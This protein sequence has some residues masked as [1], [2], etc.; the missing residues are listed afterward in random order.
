MAY[1]AL[2]KIEW[3][4]DGQNGNYTE[5]PQA[6]D[7]LR[8]T[9]LYKRYEPGTDP[10]NLFSPKNPHVWINK[11]FRPAYSY[12]EY[13]NRPMIRLAEIYLTRSI[14]RF[15]NG[16]KTGAAD[17]VNVIRRRAG[18]TDIPATS[19][20]AEDIHN[21]RIKELTSEHGDR[22]YYLIGLRL[23]L[24]IGDRDPARFSPIEPPYSDYYWDVPL[25][26]RQQNQAYH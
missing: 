1:S 7:D 22:N 12:G 20:T 5:T 25:Y 14:L 16:D 19:L 24:G 18:L 3:M 23:P 9:Q 11:Y 6:L 8:Y 10:G 17:D 13:S 15:N 21:E 26:E 4:V 2:K